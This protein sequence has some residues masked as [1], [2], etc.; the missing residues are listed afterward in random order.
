MYQEPNLILSPKA[1][2]ETLPLSIST[3]E[4]SVAVVTPSLLNPKVL[5]AAA[6]LK[7]YRLL[8]YSSPVYPSSGSASISA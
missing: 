2:T 6:P 7:P 5:S 3:L 1:L 4:T 8:S